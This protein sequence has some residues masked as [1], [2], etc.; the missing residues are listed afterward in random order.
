MQQELTMESNR[1]LINLSSRQGIRQ[2][3]GVMKS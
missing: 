2:E 1:S 3:K